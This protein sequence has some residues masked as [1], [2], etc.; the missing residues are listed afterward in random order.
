MCRRLDTCCCGCSLRQGCL[1]IAAI[2]IFYNLIQIVNYGIN[3][4]GVPQSIVIASILF[5]L[6][7]MIMP[8]FL[9]W[10][11]YK[12][13]AL[14]ILLAFIVMVIQ[15]TVSII[16][17]IAYAALV[18]GVHNTFAL[19]IYVVLNIAIIVA[20]FLYPAEVIF[21]Y[22]KELQGGGVAQGTEVS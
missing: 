2:F 11:I 12:T 18:A 15:I 13:S 4:W 5:S 3:T 14:F 20:C 19:I 17:I 9:L 10:G 22:Y 1:I 8:I 16:L 6:I 7:F 21:S